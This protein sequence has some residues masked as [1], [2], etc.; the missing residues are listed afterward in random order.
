M[1]ILILK[2]M[3]KPGIRDHHKNQFQFKKKWALHC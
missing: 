3:L 2:D 1:F